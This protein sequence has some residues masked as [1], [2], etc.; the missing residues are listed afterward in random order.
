M[1]QIKGNRMG[2]RATDLEGFF[3]YEA[4]G[5]IRRELKNHTFTGDSGLGEA[6][7]ER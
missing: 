5:E 6:F 1:I 3:G 2:S 7:S 4:C